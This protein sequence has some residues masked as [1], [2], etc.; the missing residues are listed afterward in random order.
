MLASTLS[1]KRIGLAGRSQ[2]FDAR[3]DAA[4][5][6]L[7]DLR[8]ADH[9]FAPHYAAAVVRTATARTPILEIHGGSTVSEVLQ[10][11]DFEVLEFSQG[12]AWGMGA[13]DGAV[14]FVS[15]YA[16]GPPIEVT[17]IVCSASSAQP[18]G[19]RLTAAEAAAET[20]MVAIRPLGAPIA[21][22]VAV[23]EALIGTTAVPGGRSGAGVD[24]GGLVFLTLSLAGIRA[25]RFVDLQ[26]S[27]LGHAIDGDAP[28]LRGDLLFAADRVAIVANTDTAIHVAAD[29]VR[30]DPI[31]AFLNEVTPGASIV[32]R[33]LP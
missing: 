20:E 5:G 27:A 8:L 16:L 18:M 17:H 25:P 21:D 28:M 23:A 1:R 10:G 12:H 7:A 9:L 31:A 26:A 15:C 29:G 11:E 6:D 14:G 4:R 30:S 19:S 3:I 2:A 33:R 13:V 32:R 24:A 22:Y